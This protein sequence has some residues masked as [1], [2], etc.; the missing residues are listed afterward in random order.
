MVAVCVCMFACA[1]VHAYTCVW[2]HISDGYTCMGQRITSPLLRH[3]PTFLWEVSYWP[4]ILLVV[5]SYWSVSSKVGHS[6]PAQTSDLKWA[7]CP[8]FYMHMSSE[9]QAQV[10]CLEG[11]HFTSSLQIFNHGNLRKHGDPAAVLAE[12]WLASDQ[13]VV[14]TLIV[15]PTLY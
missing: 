2:I 7:S 14:R 9:G 8:I 11:R 13:M 3:H 15:P 10:L 1:C 12:M 6:L 5:Q 4:I